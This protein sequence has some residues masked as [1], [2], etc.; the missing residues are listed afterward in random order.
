MK[1]AKIDIAG[2]NGVDKYAGVKPYYKNF[3]PRFGFAYQLMAHTVVRGGF[4]IFF[5]PTG[6]EGG[7]LRLFRQLPFGSAVSISPGDIKIN[8]GGRVRDGFPALQPV[9]FAL[10]QNPFGSMTSVDPNFKPSFANQFNLTVEHEITAWALVLKTAV[11]GNSGR[12]LYNTYNANQA[13]PGSTAVNSRRPLFAI[14]PLG[15]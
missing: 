3:G 7:S 4:G 8:V 5:N 9:N 12:D 15:S 1:T 14:A 2:Q 6:S 10:A 11:V 13:I